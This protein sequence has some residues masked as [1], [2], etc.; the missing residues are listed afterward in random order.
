MFSA[1]LLWNA[2]LLHFA[3][4][5]PPPSYGLRFTYNLWSL[6][7][8]WLCLFLKGKSPDTHPHPRKSTSS[9]RAWISPILMFNTFDMHHPHLFLIDQ[10][11]SSVGWKPRTLTPGNRDPRLPG[12]LQ[13]FPIRS[14]QFLFQHFR[15]R[16]WWFSETETGWT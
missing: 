1:E 14:C 6:G 2:F 7:F 16:H 8:V 15:Y 11:P 4:P 3:S 12:R 5:L 9:L 13:G 10:S